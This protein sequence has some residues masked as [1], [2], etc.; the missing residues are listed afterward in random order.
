MPEPITF[1]LARSLVPA[2][3]KDSH[4][5]TYGYLFVVAGSVG[6]SGAACLTCEAALRAGVGMVTL[7]LPQSLN[8]AM[9]ARLTETMTYPLPETSAQSLGLA[10]FDAIKEMSKTMHAIA[11]GPGLSSNP[12]TQRLARKIVSEIDLPMVIDAD[13]LNALAGHAGI[14]ADRFQRYLDASSGQARRGDT[15]SRLHST[16]ANTT[17]N[18]R[19]KGYSGRA[20]VQAVPQTIISPH[21]GEMSRLTGLPIS[22][23]QKD[24][25]TVSLTH[26]KKW[27]VELILKGAP[28]LVATSDGRLFVATTG[29]PGMATAGSGDVLT[30]ILAALLCQGLEVSDAALLGTYLHG[31]AGDI[32]AERF[33]PWGMIASDLISCLPDAWRRLTHP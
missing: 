25:E 7:G 9:E 20:E 13:G 12:E 33:T 6:L 11:V 15:V 28:S 31:L 21:P 16:R 18:S 30:G 17:E 4:K 19:N 2:R 1:N 5:G 27:R 22:D 10:A 14:L 23:I 24:R 26:A 32:A 29:N 8:L 3:P